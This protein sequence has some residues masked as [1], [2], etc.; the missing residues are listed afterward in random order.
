MNFTMLKERQDE[1]D[2]PEMGLDLH[3][4][5]TLRYLLAPAFEF[6]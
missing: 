2:L 5:V 3:Q 1:V 4:A 6:S